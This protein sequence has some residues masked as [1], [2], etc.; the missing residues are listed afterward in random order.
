M[1]VLP[2]I[3]AA[4]INAEPPSSSGTNDENADVAFEEFL[5]EEPLDEISELTVPNLEVPTETSSLP[6]ASEDALVSSADQ[7]AVLETNLP[8][9]PIST[10]PDLP[11]TEVGDVVDADG[12]NEVIANTQLDEV[13]ESVDSEEA[14][15]SSSESES[16]FFASE[17]S[18]DGGFEST[19]SN[20]GFEGQTKGQASGQPSAEQTSF[21]DVELSALD[22]GE[23]LAVGQNESSQ[24]AAPAANS[25]E[26]INMASV[27]SV[28]KAFQPAQANLATP[29][30]Q[31]AAALSTQI[32]NLDDEPVQTLSLELHPAELGTLK[33]R[34]E[35]TSEQ[36]VAQII[37]TE[38][39][40]TELLTREKDFLLEA[41]ADLG[42]GETSLDI[43]HGGSQQ[44][45]GDGQDQ[46]NT[47]F[48]W[49]LSD[50]IQEQPS[51]AKPANGGIN[52]IA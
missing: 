14:I 31:V 15:E 44:N 17:D 47:S 7:N 13:Q 42:L 12:P 38:I 51:L 4:S 1:N 22:G 19:N 50:E 26:P 20:E 41:L 39:S 3:T 49:N 30:T 23:R 28:A 43:S 2:N 21:A 9:D 45:E 6:F 33:I 29:A 40:S 8:T 34:V 32:T 11:G 48:P 35:Q 16:P 36:L 5:D 37:A 52:L 27:D 10:I 18:G 24:L 46:P 25:P